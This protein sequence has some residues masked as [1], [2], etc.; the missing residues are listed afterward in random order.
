MKRVITTD[1]APAA[2]GPWSAAIH[3]GD[4]VF[5]GG[6]GPI[7]PVT[8]KLK[9][10]TIQDQ[11]RLTLE[12]MKAVIEA[13]GC[14]MADVVKVQVLLTD[15]SDFQGMNDVYRTFFS[16][17]FPARMTYGT[18]LTVPNMRVEMDAIVYAGK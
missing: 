15:L 4:F 9:G 2:W 3:A 17:P 7:D 8:G 14:V 6:Q 10:T 1:K 18:A 12:N 5:V 11:T 13:A 16:E